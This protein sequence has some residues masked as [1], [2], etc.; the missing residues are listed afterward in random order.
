M[1]E[2]DAT[3]E[4]LKW[5]QHNNPPLSEQKVI[6]TVASIYRLE[7]KK[8]ETNGQPTTVVPQSTQ[9]GENEPYATFKRL[10]SLPLF[11]YDRVR[12]K[13]AEQLGIRVGTLDDEVEKLHTRDE[14][15]A[16]AGRPLALAPPDPWPA[17]VDGTDLLDEIATAI[18]RHVVL[19]PEAIVAVTLWVMHAHGFEA[20]TIS[21]RLAITAPEM[22]CGKTTLL[23][24]LEPLVPKP[25]KADNVTAAA[26]FRVVEQVRP[27]LL[28]DEADSFLKDNEELRGVLNS[29]HRCNGQAVRLV[30]ENHEPR[31]FSTFCPTAIAA[32]GRLPS[33]LED[34]SVMISM[35]R[36]LPEEAVFRFDEKQRSALVP[37]ARRARRWAEDHMASLRNAD[38][39]IPPELHGR[40]ADNWRPLFAVAEAVG[41]VWLELARA[42][43]I[44]LSDRKSA[45]H[46]SVRVQLLSDIRDL[47]VQRGAER[48]SSSEITEALGILE[49]R[50]WQDWNKG[51]SL[52]PNQ[53][54]KQL[55]PFGVKPKTMRIGGAQQPAKGY[56]RSDF[57]DAFT[58]YLPLAGQDEP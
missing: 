17:P 1:S 42:A 24:V 37:S 47:F 41:G 44:R 50:A 28:I 38:P 32:I 40:A 43:A 48:L 22:Q 56:E 35:R 46:A 49:G 26:V 11:A 27:T 45:D 14:P 51:R 7:A 33:T 23:S 18:Q 19:P 6:D 34:R 16:G 8:R 55:A 58:R 9:A 21:P 20:S 12:A 5:N 53:L 31:A 2:A 54:A 10:A 36:A 29:G 25:L 57:N 30:G 39:Q 4:V 52:T 3:A 13:E 15:P